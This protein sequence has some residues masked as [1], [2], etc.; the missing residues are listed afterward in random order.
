M[1]EKSEGD[2]RGGVSCGDLHGADGVCGA[3]YL[4]TENFLRI[5]QSD[6][7]SSGFP[8]PIITSTIEGTVRG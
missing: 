3:P 8:S 7:D 6:V 1:A 2:W 5:E 4:S